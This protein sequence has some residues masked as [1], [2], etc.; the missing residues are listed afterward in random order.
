MLRF[1]TS[2]ESHGEAIYGFLEGIPPNLDI[3]EAFI[4]KEL[5]RRRK[6]YGRSIRQ[7]EEKDS[8]RIL[9]GIINGKTTG[10]PITIEIKNKKRDSLK[11]MNVPR[12]GHADLAGAIKYGIDNIAIIAERAS[13]RETAAR[14]ALGAIAKLYLSE[15]NILITSF[16]H[17]IGN[18]KLE[19]ELYPLTN[20]EFAKV[21]IDELIESTDNNSMRCPDNDVDEKMK[22]FVE[23]TMQKGDSVGGSF[24]VIAYNI[25]VGL[26][27][28]VQW[29]QK[30]DASLSA[31]LMSIQG[32]KG[33]EFGLGFAGSLK[34]GSEYHD[35]IYY[36]KNFYRKTNRA[37]GIE[38]GMTNG[39]PIII[40]C[41]VKPPSSLQN[42]I[43]S[44]DLD[45]KQHSFAQYMRSDSCFVPA[46][47]V[48]AEAMTAL[49]ISGYI[50]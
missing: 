15:S 29:D 38:G 22:K 32:I 36:D 18:V 4:T 6:G 40:K 1:Y 49:I 25:P 3:N 9:T 13:A 7:K 41:A 45:S 21:E 43:D 24:T 34:A 16:V 11:H 42:P 5:E 12:P 31:A 30:I 33:V 50:N 19:R 26:G 14:V 2:G 10:S 27:S 39:E 23:N 46:A 48:V 8:F 44:I 47:G 20:Q 35:S 28:H 37:G 17:Q